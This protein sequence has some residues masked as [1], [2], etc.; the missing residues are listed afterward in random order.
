MSRIGT[1]NIAPSGLNVPDPTLRTIVPGDAGDISVPSGGGGALGG[2]G[3]GLQIAGDTIS[4]LAQRMLQARRAREL[5][6]FEARAFE[7]MYEAQ[8]AARQAD[9]SVALDTFAQTVQPLAD[10]LENVND[11]VLRD[12]QT[13]KLARLKAAAEV[14]VKRDTVERE[15]ILSRT[16]INETATRY[17]AAIELDKMQPGDA[18][19]LFTEAVS[20]QTGAAY[21]D[22][23]AQAVIN[24]FKID[25]VRA[26]YHKLLQQDPELA[27]WFVE[28]DELA[29]SVLPPDE[30]KRRTATADDAAQEFYAANAQAMFEDGRKAVH[31]MLADDADSLSPEQFAANVN[32]LADQWDAYPGFKIRG[33]FVPDKIATGDELK[34]ILLAEQLTLAAT[35]G[36]ARRVAVI[37]AA[38]PNT[39]DALQLITNAREELGIVLGRRARSTDGA[40]D[41][42][43]LFNS[44]QPFDAAT[45][46]GGQDTLNKFYQLA[47]GRG[48]DP[49][50]IAQ[51][52]ASHDLDMPSDLLADINRSLDPATAGPDGIGP[53]IRIL[54]AVQM[55]APQQARR[56]ASASKQ[57][58]VATVALDMLEPVDEGE[59]EGQRR[60]AEIVNVLSHSDAPRWIDRAAI[61]RW[62]DGQKREPMDVADVLQDTFGAGHRDPML[63]ANALNAF[64]SAFL[65]NV[66]AGAINLGIT[67]EEAQIEHGRRAAVNELGDRFIAIYNSQGDYYLAPA[68][69]GIG[70]E[71]NRFTSARELQDALSLYAIQMGVYNGVTTRPDLAIRVGRHAYFPAITAQG[72]VGFME[73][74]VVTHDWS[75]IR[76]E[77]SPDVFRKLSD[78]AYRRN[79]REDLKLFGRLEFS[80]LYN[81]G[82]VEEFDRMYFNGRP[83]LRDMIVEAAELDWI[84]R[85]GELPNYH[86]EEEKAEF[87]RRVDLMRR[88]LDWPAWSTTDT[89]PKKNP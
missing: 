89:E 11:P 56:I 3:T 26:E 71:N 45:A 44:G 29:I 62:G 8:E 85:T 19:Q 63:S 81:A 49:A 5:S 60:Y 78:L 61:Y 33:L 79:R 65:F 75:D 43:A 87:L 18:I 4:R 68:T 34:T 22:E 47:R 40:N 7:T 53:G 30:R 69:L 1:P 74:N 36:D 35:N 58:R 12:L 76:P 50:R 10:E 24:E 88:Q 38:M 55:V 84:G 67:D 82:S 41:L 46:P 73:W 25:A 59:P 39:P 2:L 9:P 14:Q 54:R 77:T 72:I 21:T 83:I 6:A 17:R 51:W 32:A 37:A 23:Q 48:T 86:N 42:L 70:S 57:S 20:D 80:P 52:I 13:A 64:D 27:K 15:A 28:N 16:S 66:T 31:E